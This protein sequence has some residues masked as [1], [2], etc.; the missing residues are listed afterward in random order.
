MENP[1]RTKYA[2]AGVSCI[3]FSIM[4]VSLRMDDPYLALAVIL[5]SIII[6]VFINY[7]YMKLYEYTEYLERKIEENLD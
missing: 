7:H 5:L 6:L 3:L 4:L 1:S 2:L